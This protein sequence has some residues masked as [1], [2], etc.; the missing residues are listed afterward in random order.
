MASE[1]AHIRQQIEMECEAMNRV[2][3]S[4]STKAPHWVVKMQYTTLDNHRQ[5][6]TNL[7]GEEQASEFVC[8]TCNR[9]VK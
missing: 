1:V 8:E 7:I 4:F 6:L 2:F 3:H 9:V 5:Q